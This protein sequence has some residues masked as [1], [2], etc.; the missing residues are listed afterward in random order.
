MAQG[1]RARARQAAKSNGGR[2]SR[3]KPV[4]ERAENRLTQNDDVQLVADALLI[5]EQAIKRVRLQMQANRHKLSDVMPGSQPPKT[6]EQ[7]TEDIRAGIDEIEKENK[8]LMPMVESFI[9]GR[10]AA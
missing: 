6:Y 9:E 4:I 2:R 7:Q 10:K 3:K 1:T 5:Q 8:E